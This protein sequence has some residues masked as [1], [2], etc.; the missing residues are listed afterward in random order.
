[1]YLFEKIAEERIIAAMQRGEFADLPGAG[2]P[3]PEED[4]SFIPEDQRMAYRIIR[5]AGFLPPELELQQQIFVLEET[6]DRENDMAARSKIGK[7][8]V[9]M[10]RKLSASHQR[11]Q[12]LSLQEHYYQRIIQRLSG[13]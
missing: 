7:K 3:L 8:L 13:T 6:L 9:C 12:H 11:L 2:K 1:M 5:N 10:Y 4:L